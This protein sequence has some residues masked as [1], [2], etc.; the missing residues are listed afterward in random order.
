MVDE[1]TSEAST[2]GGGRPFGSDVNAAFDDAI[3]R[4]KRK[5]ALREVPAPDPALE[6]ALADSHTHLSMLRSPARSLA[7]AAIH[8]VGFVCC[9]TDPVEDADVVYDQID[10]WFADAQGMAQSWT[11]DSAVQMPAY[12]VACGCHPHEAR[13]F[14]ADA[15]SSLMGHLAD[16][17]TCCVGEVG[18][19]YHYDYSPRD[20]QRDVFRRQIGIAHETGLPIALHLR[21]AHDDALQIMDEEG[22]PEAGTILHCFNLG[23]DVLAP[24][25]ERGCFVA[26]GGAV[27]F[28]SSDDLRD[29]LPLV[30]RDR[31]LLETD[32]PYMAPAPFRSVECSPDLIA[33]TAQAVAQELGADPGGSREVLLSSIYEN[34]VDLLDREATAWQTG[35]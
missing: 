28:G 8:G 22:F 13:L 14:D 19:D 20:V 10:T 23:A 18:L 17:R 7:R 31:L 15:R 34:T 11:G 9:I 6:H 26:V 27:T 1:A 25:V 4:T 29:A 12:R 2:P 21:E 16:P 32:G 35:R 3:F 24:W 33:F 5:H 30:P